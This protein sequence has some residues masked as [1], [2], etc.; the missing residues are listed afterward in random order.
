MGERTGM[1]DDGSSNDRNEEAD[2]G[3]SATPKQRRREI[4]FH[5]SYSKKRERNARLCPI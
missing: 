4:M 5:S 1:L 3:K 2:E